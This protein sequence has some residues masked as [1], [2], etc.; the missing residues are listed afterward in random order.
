[1]LWAVSESNVRIKLLYIQATLYNCLHYWGYPPSIV[2]SCKALS[3]AGF[4]TQLKYD[5]KQVLL[6]DIMTMNECYATCAFL[7]KYHVVNQHIYEL[8]SQITF[9]FFQVVEIHLFWL[10]ENN[11]QG[12]NN[13][14]MQH[15][16][17]YIIGVHYQLYDTSIVF[18]QIAKSSAGFE[19]R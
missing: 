13:C 8:F 6:L 7:V 14:I 18:S 12:N 5:K 15:V 4:V 11:K 10:R 2:F 17:Y 9:C 1:M 3:S 19:R 16:Y